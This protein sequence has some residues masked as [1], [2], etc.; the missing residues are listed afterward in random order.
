MDLTVSFRA[1]FPPRVLGRYDFRETR[2]AAALLA[3]IHPTEFAEIVAVL[4]AFRLEADDFLVPGG[5]KGTV[6]ARLDGM[7]RA[8]GWREARFDTEVKATMRRMPYRKGGERKATTHET[9]VA[10]K[11]YKVDNYKGGV[12]LDV[13][14]NAK[15]GNL[16][17]DVG[18]YRAFY[19]AG[20][21]T[22][23][24]ILTRT[25]ADLRA[26]GER[27]GRDPLGTSTT[28]NLEKLEPRM[29]RGDG[30]GCPLLAVAITARCY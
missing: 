20:A 3:S 6:A 4:D 9:V 25:T 17:R 15:D 29:T 30:G 1:A 28:T 14:W 10:S 24:V 26:L 2:A 5:A 8:A 13:E 19:E 22:A 27:L 11:G 21:I 12:A 18:A 7:F 16:D 23:G